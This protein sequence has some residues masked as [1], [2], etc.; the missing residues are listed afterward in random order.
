MTF[1]ILG[2]D[3]KSDVAELYRQS[4]EPIDPRASANVAKGAARA[5]PNA[6]LNDRERVGRRHSNCGIPQKRGD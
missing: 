6:K 2:V 1:S 3:D 4:L 5:V